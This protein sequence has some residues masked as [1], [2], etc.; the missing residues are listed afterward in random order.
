MGEGVDSRDCYEFKGVSKV[1]KC[2]YST[3]QKSEILQNRRDYIIY[4]LL[5]SSDMYSE[6]L[7]CLRNGL[8]I[9]RLSDGLGNVEDGVTLEVTAS[10]VGTLELK[11]SL[12]EN[13]NTRVGLL[14]VLLDLEGCKD[15]P[16]VF[17]RLQSQNVYR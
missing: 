15:L 12:A 14:D 7:I 9:Q 11:R 8:N 17:H 10:S 2:K 4:F 16:L 13:G 5:L 1:K 3:N 6:F